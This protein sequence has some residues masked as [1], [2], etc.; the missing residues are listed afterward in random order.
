V[1]GWKPSKNGE[2]IRP[3]AAGLGLGSHEDAR[4]AERLF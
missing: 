3:D 2:F 4:R 1:R